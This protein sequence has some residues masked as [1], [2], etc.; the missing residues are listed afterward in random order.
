M[1]EIN[2]LQITNASLV[3]GVSAV[4]ETAQV[5]L[6]TQRLYKLRYIIKWSDATGIE[7]LQI[8]IG[9]DLY[10][11]LSRIGELVQTRQIRKRELLCLKFVNP[12]SFP[13]IVQPH[14][15]VLNHLFQGPIM[16]TPTV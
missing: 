7:S 6:Q 14:F 15:V 3:Q 1:S 10:P 16:I 13:V 11:V 2:F 4:I 9:V 12:N 8:K 5:E